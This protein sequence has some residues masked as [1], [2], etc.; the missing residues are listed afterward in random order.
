MVA[1]MINGF[2][3]PKNCCFCPFE[4]RKVCCANMHP[5]SDEERKPYVK[6]VSWCPLQEVNLRDVEMKGDE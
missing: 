1:V 4:R 2:E 3:M 5:V 6:R